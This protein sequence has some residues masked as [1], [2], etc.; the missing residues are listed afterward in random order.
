MSNG[1]QVLGNRPGKWW[2]RDDSDQRI[3]CDLCPR[4][5]RMKEGDRGF[6]FVRKIE[7]DQMV[8]DTYGKSTGFCIDPIEKK[9]LNHFYPGTSVLSFGTAGCNLGCQFCQNWDISKSREVARLSAKA[10]PDVIAHAAKQLACTSVAYTYN[11]PVVWAE[12]AIDTA[13]ECRARG[14][15]NVAVTAGYISPDARREFFSVMDAANV[16]LKAF[17]E[18]FYRKITYSKLEPV[19]DTLRY[20]KHETDVWFE[21]TNLV[22]P[23]AN[24]S[25]DELKRMCE[26][27]VRDL[28][29]DVPVHFSAF[30]PDFRMTDRPRTPH[31]TLI[32]A[33]EIAQAAGIYYPYVG[34]VHDID[35]GST[36]CYQCK[37]V[38]IE[39]DWYQL[40]NYKLDGNQCINCGAAQFGRFGASPGDWGR[41][42]Q[43]VD[44]ESFRPME[45]FSKTA[46]IS[47]PI[48]S[49]L[50]PNGVSNGGKIA[51]DYLPSAVPVAAPPGDINSLIRLKDAA[52]QNMIALSR[53][54]TPSCYTLDAMEGNVNALVFSLV[55]SNLKKPLA[56]WIKTSLRPG[57]A[58]QSTLF[59]LCEAA[60]DV[61]SK[62]RF[63]QNVNIEFAV[64]V[65]FDPA[66][67]G[68]ID[69]LDWQGSELKL[70]L[71]RCELDGANPVHRGILA[72][73]ADRVAVAFDVEKT[74]E[75]LVNEAASAVRIGQQ[76]VQIFSLSCLST[77]NSLLATNA[78]TPINN[79][80]A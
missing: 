80:V 22:I 13:R 44:L 42:R 17:S 77:A 49:A 33:F 14:I 61:L 37:S 70:P 4:Q 24:D 32:A 28:G 10:E 35:R 1:N 19:L 46:P 62:T 21:I 68:I 34:N 54:A 55:D 64:T 78:T 56:H 60:T 69:D 65:L 57:F 76:P 9:P 30:H 63:T 8:L 27:I 23:D 31:E 50:R 38:I 5:C 11:D 3:V 73:C 41:K 71:S 20:L 47:L 72:L 15:Q 25:H 51:A 26:W 7:D 79:T 53:G 48:L 43:P 39:R 52:T 36:K 66:Q 45:R 74:I 67:H 2:H 18:D 58:L 29:P 16:D 6:C 40:G 12:Y 75:Q 59:Q